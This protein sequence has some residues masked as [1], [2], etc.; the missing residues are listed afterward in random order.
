MEDKLGFDEVRKAFANAAMCIEMGEY[1][2]AFKIVDLTLGP[3]YRQNRSLV[4]I[5]IEE[6]GWGTDVQ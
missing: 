1:F 6:K 2:T 3:M 5:L 4:D